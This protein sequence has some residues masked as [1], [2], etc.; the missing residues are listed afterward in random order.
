MSDDTK[1]PRCDGELAEDHR[2]VGYLLCASCGKRVP[3]PPPEA[4]DLTRY[5]LYTLSLPERAAR[6]TIA[7]ASGA[8]R[9]ASEFLVPRGFQ[10][11]KTYEI[12]V[13]NS[14]RF[15]TEDVGKTKAADAEETDKPADDYLAR[16]A[17]GNFVDLAGLSMMHLSPMWMLAIISDV[18]YG[19]K[20]YARELA[21]ELKM[22]GLIDE[23]ST[24]E[25]IDDVLEA[26]RHTSGHA[27]GLID[28][29]PLSVEELKKSLAE[30]R[31]A[32]AA[33]DFSAVLPEAE[34]RN[35]WNEMREI[36]GREQVSLLNV[37]TAVTMHSVNKMRSVAE[38]T[39]TGVTV[40]G[41]LFNDVV[42]GHYSE[43][44]T[45]LKRD[46]FYATV[47]QCYAPYIDA[48]WTNFSADETTITEGVLDG[49]LVQRAYRTMSG[50]W[51]KPP[52][53]VGES[54]PAAPAT[55]PKPA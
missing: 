40:A 27:A 41:I 30:T 23:H 32:I 31:E 53:A 12:V 34:L 8:A 20:I 38:G 21:T 52:P 1:C 17:V 42:I 46:G 33:A 24:I 26:V 37:S 55:P 4:I 45:M 10:S 19:S 16:K 54:L 5:L 51:R 14:L 7:L 9:E 28:A 3:L 36:A 47:H 15:L 35:Y 13:R 29:P 22:Q 11:S 6:S 43:A 44:L 18:A 2:V 49:S 39:L 25:R 48:V 50:W